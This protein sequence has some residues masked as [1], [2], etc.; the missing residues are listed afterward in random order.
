MA[1]LEIC[2]REDFIIQ[3]GS[4]IILVRGLINLDRT[5]YMNPIGP[6]FQLRAKIPVVE[7]WEKSLQAQI[8]GLEILFEKRMRLKYFG[9]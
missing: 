6:T 5:P 3:S 4:C 9:E 7:A 2:S 8:V 1:G